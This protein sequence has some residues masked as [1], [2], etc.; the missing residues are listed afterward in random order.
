M[1]AVFWIAIDDNLDN[2]KKDLYPTSLCKGWPYF[3]CSTL[4]FSIQP[5]GSGTGYRSKCS[6]R[7]KLIFIN[8]VDCLANKVQQYELNRD[9][10]VIDE[11]FAHLNNIGSLMTMTSSI[12]LTDL[13]L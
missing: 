5:A 10:A 3:S 7:N 12:A 4:S 2:P 1:S 9:T 6:A 8:S 13:Y 11:M